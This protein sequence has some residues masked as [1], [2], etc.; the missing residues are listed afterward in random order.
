MTSKITVVIP[1]FKIE[2]FKECLE[3]LN[4]QEVRNFEIIVGNDA[5]KSDAKSIINN[6]K[7]LSVKYLDFDNNL[8]GINLVDHWIRCVGQVQ[9]EYFIILG[10]DDKLSKNAISEFY[11]IEANNKYS[12]YRYDVKLI[13]G[14][15]KEISENIRYIDK[16]T[17]L[18]FFI[19][20][21]HNEVRN[22]LGE[23]IFKLEDFKKYGIKKF[24]KAF[25]SDNWMITIYS[26]FGSIKNI[27]DATSYIRVFKG[28]LSGNSDNKLI[29]TKVGWYFYFHFLF[30]YF[31]RFSLKQKIQLFLYLIK[32]FPIVLMSD[33][34]IKKLNK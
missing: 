23:Y 15:G 1:F 16:E 30:N 21:F 18:D 13:D 14:A 26:N 11:K 20:K 25:Y 3:S 10:D 4:N 9:T 6:F 33:S 5:S 31:N 7:D 24:T 32:R 28:S 19:K 27:E 8:G 34:L 12:V 22:S 17:S 2:F 29:I